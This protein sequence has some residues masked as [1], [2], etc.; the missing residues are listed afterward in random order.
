MRKLQKACLLLLYHLLMLLHL[1]HKEPEQLTDFQESWHH[2]QPLTYPFHLILSWM[3]YR[4]TP[5]CGNRILHHRQLLR[6]ESGTD[7][8]I[9]HYGIPYTSEDS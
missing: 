5:G 4:M 9:S 2:S 3:K 6:T 7:H 8:L 1:L